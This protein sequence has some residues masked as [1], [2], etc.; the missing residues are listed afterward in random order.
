MKPYWSMFMSWTWCYFCCHFL[1]RQETWY[2]ILNVDT[3]TTNRKQGT[4]QSHLN[5]I[6]V[7]VPMILGSTV[8]MIS[9]VLVYCW[10]LTWQ[11]ESEL[12]AVRASPVSLRL[13]K[14]RPESGNR[15][16]LS[17]FRWTQDRHM[18]ATTAS[19]QNAIGTWLLSCTR[20]GYIPWW[21]WGREQRRNCNAIFL[22]FSKEA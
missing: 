19:K 13:Q 15:M 18:D 16:E 11:F 7:P 9:I 1:P 10:A 2:A 20:R 4:A 3:R 6:R 12:A 22:L 14:L 8:T 17:Y 5:S 21:P